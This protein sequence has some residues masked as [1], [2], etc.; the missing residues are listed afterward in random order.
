M[1]RVGFWQGFF[2]QGGRGV[3]VEEARAFKTW[4]QP[5][6][7]PARDAFNHEGFLTQEL[8]YI[9]IYVFKYMVMGS[10]YPTA[11]SGLRYH[12]TTSK[13]GSWLADFVLRGLAE[14]GVGR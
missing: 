1:N 9:Y 10:S 7:R 12:L 11:T 2:V 4:S 6:P 8:A 14:E 3:L 5:G 13:S